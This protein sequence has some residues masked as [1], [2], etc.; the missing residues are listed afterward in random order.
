MQEITTGMI[1][2]RID[3]LKWVDMEGGR[4]EK[5]FTHRKM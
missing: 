1:E 3:D 5:N 4:R 2:K